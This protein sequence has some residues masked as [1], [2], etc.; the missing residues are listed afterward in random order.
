MLEVV[1]ELAR[2]VGITAE[3][4]GM[5]AGNGRAH[6]RVGSS[7]QAAAKRLPGKKTVSTRQEMDADA[8][9]PLGDDFESF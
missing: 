4:G 8:V 5:M 6:K 7:V 1:G 9:I 2:M 3:H